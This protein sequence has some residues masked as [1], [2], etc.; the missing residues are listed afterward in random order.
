[1]RVVLPLTTLLA[2]AILGLAAPAR[3]AQCVTMIFLDQYGAVI[4]TP[5]PVVGLLLGGEPILGGTAPPYFTKK[6]GAPAPCQRQ[7]LDR[8]LEL[9]NNSCPTEERRNQA[10][11]DNKADLS[12]I[13]KGCANMAEALHEPAQ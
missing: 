7:L 5:Q 3:A 12:V 10:A 6:T 4:Q 8:V 13:N 11:K 1:M 9:F 2:C